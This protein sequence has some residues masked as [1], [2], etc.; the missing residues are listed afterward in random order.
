LGLRPTVGESADVLLETHLLD[1]NVDAYGKLV[2]VEILQH[3]RDEKKFSDLSTLTIA[4][5]QD[6]QHAIDYFA[7]HGLQDNLKPD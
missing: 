1:A 2:C 5:Q 3:V 6:R 4:M 7:H